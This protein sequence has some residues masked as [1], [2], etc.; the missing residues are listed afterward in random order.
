MNRQSLRPVAICVMLANGLPL[1][2]QQPAGMP[3][4]S[5]RQ[6]SPSA[7]VGN[8]PAAAQAPGAI[9]G[10]V[11]YTSGGPAVNAA[12][13]LRDLQTGRIT[14]SAASNTSGTFAFPSV[15]P[16]LY[17]VEAVGG[18]KVVAASQIVAVKPGQTVSAFLGLGG[19][20]GAVGSTVAANAAVAAI[21]IGAAAAVGILAVQSGDCVSPPC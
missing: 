19:L 20:L 9:E 16:G 3:L 17:V 8:S 21:V 7:T 4:P 11:K 15:N 5:V 18:G 13:R 1:L 2:A 14:G 10:Q 6:V 12:L